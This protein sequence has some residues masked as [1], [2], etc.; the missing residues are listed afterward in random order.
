MFIVLGTVGNTD[1]IVLVQPQAVNVKVRPGSAVQ[2]DFRIG[3]SRQYP[4][5]L[6]FLL[7]LSWSMENT[8][9]TVAEKGLSIKTFNNVIKKHR[10]Y[11][12]LYFIIKQVEIQA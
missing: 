1:N 11:N 9:K 8:T 10:Y 5:D 2:L 6:Y 3:Q 12:N 7:D 4:L